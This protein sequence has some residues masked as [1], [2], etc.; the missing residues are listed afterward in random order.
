MQSAEAEIVRAGLPDFVDSFRSDATALY[1][2]ATGRRDLE[3]NEKWLD[4]VDYRDV[5]NLLSERRTW[6][7]GYHRKGLVERSDF[8]HRIPEFVKRSSFNDD[9]LENYTHGLDYFFGEE[10]VMSFIHGQLRAF[11]C[12]VFKMSWDARQQRE[13]FAVHDP[14]TID[15]SSLWHYVAFNVSDSADAGYDALLE[16][17]PKTADGLSPKT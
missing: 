9:L 14:V 7:W 4:V 16:S 5:S 8:I 13:G 3:K 6:S 1:K 11:G 10:E 17:V 2:H 12:N 15:E